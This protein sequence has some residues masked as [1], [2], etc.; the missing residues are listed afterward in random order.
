MCHLIT[1]GDDRVQRT[2]YQLLKQAA[3]KRTE[4]YVVEAAVEVDNN[5]EATLPLELLA[6]LLKVPDVLDGPRHT[7]FGFLIGWS[8]IFDLFSG[9]V[10]L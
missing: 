1:D 8:I 2:A 5:F 10:R 6:I 4:H 3:Y 7:V 9:S